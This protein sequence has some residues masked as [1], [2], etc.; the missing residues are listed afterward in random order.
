MG[1]QYS[2]LYAQKSFKYEGIISAGDQAL[3][4]YMEFELKNDT[5]SGISITDKNNKNETKNKIKGT[6]NKKEKV[7]EIQELDVIETSSSE[8]IDTFCYLHLILK[9]NQ[10]SKL[11]GKFTGY[12]SNDSV[13]AA[14]DVLL[15]EREKI[16]KIKK[17]VEKKIKKIIIEDEKVLISNDTVVVN[18]NNKKTFI[19]V[20]DSQKEDGDAITLLINDIILL[21]E[22]KASLLKKSIS[23]NLNEGDN[24]IKIIANSVGEVSPNT[25]AFE[26]ATE[27][28]VFPFK[29]NLNLDEAAIIKIQ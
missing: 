17:I 11:E 8:S 25:V 9:K 3:A 10:K 22:Y 20:W 4:Y 12:F 7:F 23:I 29:T 16:K 24:Y 19:N 2:V 6:Y 18:L 27:T 26:I 28:Q 14:G 1:T 5:L 13:C 15:I 21:K